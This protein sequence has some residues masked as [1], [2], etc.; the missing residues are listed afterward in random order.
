MSYKFVTILLNQSQDP[1]LQQS[2]D[3][4]QQHQHHLM[5]ASLGLGTHQ[6][7]LVSPQQLQ[8]DPYHMSDYSNRYTDLSDTGDQMSH[9]ENPGL[10]DLHLHHVE[11]SHR[12][13]QY[14]PCPSDDSQCE[15]PSQTRESL[16]SALLNNPYLVSGYHLPLQVPPQQSRLCTVKS[17]NAPTA[18]APKLPNSSS[19]STGSSR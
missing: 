17:L 8:N 3:S 14:T 10:S 9:Y 11:G 18:M 12:A 16:D 2:P 5:A 4:L 19:S 7:H 1:S 13:G 6:H 15:S